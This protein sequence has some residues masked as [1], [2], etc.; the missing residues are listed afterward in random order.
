MNIG[1]RR[2]TVSTVGIPE[3][4]ARLAALGLQVNL[5]VSLHAPTDELRARLMPYGNLLKVDELMG[6][7]EDFFA[8]TGREVTFEYVLLAGVN[9]SRKL[10]ERL[11][12]KVKPCH[13]SVNLI[14]Y[15]EVQGTPFRK[16]SADAVK[17]FRGV[18]EKHG[19]RVTC[20]RARGTGVAAACGQLRLDALPRDDDA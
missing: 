10:A 5:A 7:A 13:A 19:V 18:L 20:R 17:A 12:E 1:A 2:M 8:N 4:I 15:N 6:E 14:A 9:D 16:P 11:A 3:T